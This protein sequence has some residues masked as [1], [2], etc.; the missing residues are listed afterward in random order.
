MATRN[1]DIPADQLR[2][3]APACIPRLDHADLCALYVGARTGGDFF[4]FFDV[5]G[6]LVFGLFDIAGRR[7][8]AFH[9]AAALQELLRARIPVLLGDPAANTAEGLTELAIVV[10]AGVLEAAGGVCCCP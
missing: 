1:G 10:N 5:K 8:Q 7:A 4:E 3:P 9:I 2:Q 6:A